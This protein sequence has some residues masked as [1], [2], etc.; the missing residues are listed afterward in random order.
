MSETNIQNN[1]QD[2]EVII[3]SKTDDNTIVVTSVEELSQKWI[4]NA[5][6]GYDSSNQKYSAYLSDGNSPSNK[7]T[8][9]YLDELAEGSQNDINKVKIINSIIR[10]Q[11]NKNDIVGK[12]VE[13]IETNINTE[14]K[15]SY[16]VEIEGRNKS[17]QLS[18]VKSFIKNFND[19]I[20]IKKLVRSAITTPYCEGTYIAYLKHKEN[21]GYVVDYYP[22]G[23]CELSDYD[24]N[25]EPVVLF[26]VQELRSRLQKSYKKNKKNNPLFFANIDEEVQANYPEEVYKAFKDKEQ[27]AKLDTKYT[28]II[29]IGNMNRKYGISPIFR[30]LESL[31]ML[32]TFDNA[33]RVNSK[34]KAKKI[35]HQ[36]LR[37]EVL[38]QS[39]DKKGFEEMAYAHN[40]FMSAWKQSTVV[41]TSPA[42]V[43]SILYVEPKIEMT[44][45]DTV[46]NYRSRVLSTLGIGFLMDS[47]SQSVSTANI[48]VTQLMRTINK[49]SEQ[50]EDILKKWYKQILEDNNLPVE[51][52]P[53]VE[54]IDSEQLEFEL[55]KDLA[56]LLFCK[57]NTS[58]ETAFNILGLSVE[59][60]KQKRIKENDE[61]LNEIFFPRLT[62]YTGS[63]NEPV[64]PNN[65]KKNGRPKGEEN[66]KQTYDQNRQKTL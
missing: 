8:P 3:T 51:Y 11:I 15:L 57:F 63:G 5:M 4:E 17:K 50:L 62:S 21:G 44:N 6:S 16:D 45:K 28:G 9:E 52:C 35:I 56:E 66:N 34:A 55:K 65:E 42:T 31:S 26:N 18:N 24:V 47:S 48:S 61:N 22:L 23:V 2:F 13:S 32:E 53:K 1:E 49:I 43:E 39:F 41:V 54:V 37:K 46:N 33:D 27:Y 40:N 30:S 25:G 64:S 60:E 36:K 10:K 29:R 20:K 58:Y 38:G 19:E 59:D 14:V 12:T 7:I